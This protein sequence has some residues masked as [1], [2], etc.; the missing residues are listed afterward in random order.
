[1]TDVLFTPIRLNELETLIQN[2]VERALK[3]NA[4]TEQASTQ[5]E[6]FLTI[7]EAA[8]F[9]SLTVPTMYSKCSKN[10]IS[11]M[12]RGKRL[13]FSRIELMEYLKA[14]RKKSNNEIEAEA[15]KYL[16]NKKRLNNG[17]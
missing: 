5:T 12:K 1:M 13:Y 3:A 4:K 17:K 14:G 6:Q 16:T 11:F 10:E 9:L 15:L 8:Q 7:Q 2:S